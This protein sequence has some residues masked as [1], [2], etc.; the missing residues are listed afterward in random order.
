[1]ALLSS[2]ISS[3]DGEFTSV[4]KVLKHR[5]ER[6]LPS[7]QRTSSSDLDNIIRTKTFFLE[8]SKQNALTG[9]K[10]GSSPVISQKVRW[11]P[12][13]CLRRHGSFDSWGF[14]MLPPK[15]FTNSGNNC[16]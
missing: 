13:I 5:L 2:H 12:G 14:S 7:V 1:M 15:T 8:R 10:E 11:M 3:F 9:I 16:E 4:N 6:S